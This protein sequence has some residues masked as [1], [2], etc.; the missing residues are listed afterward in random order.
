MT[1]WYLL[2]YSQ[3][4][5]AA[6]YVLA[7]GAGLIVIIVASGYLIKYLRANIKADIPSSEGFT[8]HDLRSMH[9]AGKLTD[10]E[11]EVAKNALLASFRKAKNGPG[12]TPDTDSDPESPTKPSPPTT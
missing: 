11:Y 10:T 9:K 8:L 2:A 7:G 3:S 6:Y 5:Q 1:I 4:Q 12:A